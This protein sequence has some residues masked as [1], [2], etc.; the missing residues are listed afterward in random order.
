MIQ[1]LQN[2]SQDRRL[3][4]FIAKHDIPLCH[5]NIH[6]WGMTVMLENEDISSPQRFDVQISHNVF[7]CFAEA[8]QVILLR[9]VADAVGTG[10]ASCAL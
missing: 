9:H 7:N 2:T 8:L 5:T 3:Q 4:H 6:V 1:L 10:H